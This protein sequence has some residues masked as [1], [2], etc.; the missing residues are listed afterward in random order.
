M[1]ANLPGIWPWR[2]SY[3]GVGTNRI[4]C[5]ST[6]ALHGEDYFR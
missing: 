5:D 2:R 3:Y 6:V 1:G 4:D